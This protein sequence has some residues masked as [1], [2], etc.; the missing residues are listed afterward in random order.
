[1]KRSSGFVIND[2]SSKGLGA[3][4]S[5]ARPCALGEVG[6]ESF[7]WGKSEKGGGPQ[8]CWLARESSRAREGSLTLVLVLGVG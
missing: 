5:C 6:G 8:I 1:M 4:I 7:Q 3:K 2:A